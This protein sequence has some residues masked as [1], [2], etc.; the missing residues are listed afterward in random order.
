MKRFLPS[1]EFMVAVFVMVATAALAAVLT[2][3]SR[4]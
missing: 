4:I 2:F 1:I 3:W